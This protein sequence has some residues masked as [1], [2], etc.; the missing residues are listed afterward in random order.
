MTRSTAPGKLILCGEHAVVYGQPAIAVPVAAVSATATV[1]D[2]SNER[3]RSSAGVEALAGSRAGVEALAGKEPGIVVELPDIGERWRVDDRPEHP[4]ALLIGQTL[5]VL[6]METIPSL[7]IRLESTIPI[8]GGMGSGA[9]LSAAL[10]RALAEHLGNPL[11]AG[12]V[13]AL[14]YES[15]RFYHGTPSGIDNTVVSYGQPV[16]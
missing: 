12:T 10:V 4:L 1:S 8:A 3:D 5:A 9:A 2:G 6:G 7:A 13:S 14:V 15:E 16:W 11:D